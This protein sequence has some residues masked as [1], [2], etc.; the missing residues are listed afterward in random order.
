[1][2][3]GA[4]V[5]RAHVGALLR[6]D[7]FPDTA[8]ARVPM[9]KRRIIHS[10]SP[11]SSCAPLGINAANDTSGPWVSANDPVACPFVMTEPAVVTHLGVMNGSVAGDSVDIGVYDANWVRMVS[12]GSQTPATASGFDFYDVTDTPLPSGQYFCVISRN[13]VN[14]NRQMYFGNTASALLC[15]LFGMQDSATDAF[16]LPN[17]LTNMA[18]AATATRVPFWAVALRAPFA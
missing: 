2:L 6:R 1:M 7:I 14:V 8:Y 10:A 17:P 18:A 12:T 3:R 4:A 15:S 16:P 5:K 13:N 11:E 9:T